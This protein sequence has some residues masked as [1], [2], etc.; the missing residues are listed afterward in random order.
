MNTVKLHGAAQT[1][2]ERAMSTDEVV[3]ILRMRSQWLMSWGFRDCIKFEDVLM[4][5]V[6]GHHHNGWVAISL[7]WNDTYTV[8]LF[9]TQ[10]KQKKQIREVYVDEL[11]DTLDV[12]I[13]RIAD[14]TS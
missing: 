9:S 11:L 13:E 8:T 7:G 2:K 1:V 4:F 12:A 14:Y 6:S 3:A 10:M 5:R